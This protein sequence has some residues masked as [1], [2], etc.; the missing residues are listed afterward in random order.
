[1]ETFGAQAWTAERVLFTIGTYE[2]GMWV[3]GAPRHP[4]TR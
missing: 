4:R 2:G 3:Y 1:M